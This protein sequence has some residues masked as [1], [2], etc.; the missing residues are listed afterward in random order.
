MA[1]LTGAQGVATG[2]SHAALLT[3]NESWEQACV[4][5]GRRSGDLCHPMIYCPELHFG[6][7]SSTLADMKNSTAVNMFELCLLHRQRFVQLLGEKVVGAVECL[8]YCI[9]V[10]YVCYYVRIERMPRY[11]LLVFSSALI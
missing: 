4:V 3:N 7:F 8:A 1:T 6:D 2:R 5:A 9:P 11:R 10:L